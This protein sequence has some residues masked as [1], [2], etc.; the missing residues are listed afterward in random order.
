MVRGMD[1][2][3]DYFAEYIAVCINWRCSLRHIVS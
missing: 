1:V 3:R 2:F